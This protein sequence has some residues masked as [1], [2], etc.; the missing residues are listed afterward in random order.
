MG[1]EQVEARPRPAEDLAP[2][3][4]QATPV[5]PFAV[6]EWAAGLGRWAWIIIGVL[7]LLIAVAVVGAALRVVVA[8]TLFAVLFG[9]TFLP[10]VD[11]SAKRRLPRWLGALLVLLLMILIA[12]AIVLIIVYGIVNQVPTIAT[13][14]DDALDTVKT[15]LSQAQVPTATVD[16]VKAGMQ[17]AAG[18]AASGILGMLVQGIQSVA[19]LVFG[20]FI[21]INIMVWVLI[22]GRKL[23]RWASGHM[24]PVP[25]PVAY[26]IIANSARFFR[27]YMWGSTIT[28]LFNGGV[29]FVGSLVIGV[30]MAAT[31]GI[32]GWLTNYIP[33][34]GA[35]ISGIFAVLI[36]LGSGGWSMAIPM[37]IIVILANGFLQ[38]IVSQFALGGALKLH[39]LAVLFATTSGGILFGA[40]GGVFAAPFLKITLDAY[41]RVKEANVF[42]DTPSLTVTTLAGAELPVAVEAAGVGPPG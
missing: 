26:S 27:G 8:A 25:P 14:V 11:W 10:I 7:I 34:F 20:V 19:L 4:T 28:G 36:A 13:T 37:L 16:D 9:G 22:Q 12:V 41:A 17:K 2:P 6:P 29:L 38:T 42:S 30:P 32:I 39:P 24:G 21:S 5:P 35:I 23:A 1:N 31:I 40:I 18:A 33:Y 3:E 15:S